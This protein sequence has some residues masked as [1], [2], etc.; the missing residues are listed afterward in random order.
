MHRIENGIELDW[1]FQIYD[2]NELASNSNYVVWIY[3]EFAVTIKGC[4]QFQIWFGCTRH[5]I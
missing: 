3:L 5:R 1:K 4:N 2:G